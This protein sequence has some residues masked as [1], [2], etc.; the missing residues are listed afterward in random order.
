[1]SSFAKINVEC[2]CTRYELKVLG[3]MTNVQKSDSSQIEARTES[4][5]KVRVS[6]SAVSLG[7]LVPQIT[8]SR[9]SDTMLIYISSSY[10]KILNPFNVSQG[11]PRESSGFLCVKVLSSMGMRYGGPFLER[12]KKPVLGFWVTSISALPEEKLL[13]FIYKYLT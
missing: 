7:K 10:K 11:T 12:W 13:R 5:P 6:Q 2:G 8:T 1:M 4:S 3:Q 9:Q